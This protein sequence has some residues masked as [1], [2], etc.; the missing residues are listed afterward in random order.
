[1]GIIFDHGVEDDEEL[2]S[3][4]DADGVT[5][6]SLAFEF[7]V[8]VFDDGVMGGRGY[9]GHVKCGSDASSASED[10]AFSFEFPAVT[11]ERSET[12]QRGD[13][14]PVELS[15][16]RDFGNER[17]GGDISDARYGRKEF[18]FV[19]PLIVGFDECFH[20]FFEDMDL[21]VEEFDSLKQTLSDG[22]VDDILKSTIFSFSEFDELSSSGDELIKIVLFFMFLSECPGSDLIS[23][24]GDDESINGIGFGKNA[25]ADG[26]GPHLS[27]I[28]ESDEVPSIKQLMD[29][30]FLVSTGGLKNDEDRLRFGESLNE[31]GDAFAGIFDLSAKLVFG[32]RVVQFELGH[33][34]AEEHVEVHFGCVP[35]LQM[36]ARFLTA[37]AAVRAESKESRTILLDH[38][39]GGRRRLQRSGTGGSRSIHD[40]RGRG[41]CAARYL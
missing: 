18:G 29:E 17:S 5:G 12:Y 39:L 19:I 34:D 40:R 27:G 33:V 15:K 7:I 31:F 35:S 20:F 14:L 4:G 9:G 10:S 8:E 3:A 38:R 26:K 28:D 22:F 25:D 6:F 1:M 11:V 37:L 32:V 2:S 23:E 16:F 13:L 21:L 41:C 24:V 30:S 36:R